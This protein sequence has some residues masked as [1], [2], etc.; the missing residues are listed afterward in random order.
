MNTQP[1]A[2]IPNDEDLA[3]HFVENCAYGQQ[4]WDGFNIWREGDRY[5]YVWELSRVDLDLEVAWLLE[6]RDHSGDDEMRDFLLVISSNGSIITRRFNKP[7]LWRE[8]TG[9]RIL[10]GLEWFTGQVGLLLLTDPMALD[11]SANR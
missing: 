3:R 2:V 9:S 5:L 6:V 8:T 4:S 10:E 1:F 7:V 11:P